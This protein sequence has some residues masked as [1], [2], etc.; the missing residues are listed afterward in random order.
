M[1]TQATFG[2]LFSYPLDGLTFA[3]PLY[4]ANVDDPGPGRPQRRL[5]RDRAR[6]ASTPSTRTAGPARRSGRTRS[7]TRPPAS[8][9]IPPA[10]T[11]ETEDIPNEIGITG[12]PVIDP[13]T[14]TLYLVA[15]TKEVTGGTTNYVNRLHALDLTTGAEKFGGPVVITATV[16]GTGV[17]AVNGEISFNNITA[18]PAAG[19]AARER[20]R[21]T[22]PS[23][24]HGFNPPYHG[25]VMAY[26]ATTLQS[27]LGL[28][29]DA[30]RRR[31]AASGWAATASPPTPP[32]SLYFST[33]NGTFDRSSGGGDYG[34]SL[35]K[36]DAERHGLR[37]LHAAQLA[38]ASTAV[39]STSRS[40]GVVL[41]PDQPGAHPHE[42]D[43]RRQGRDGLRRRPRQHGPRQRRRTT[44]RSS[45]RSSTSSRRAARTTRATT[46]RRSTSTAA[47][48]FVPVKGPVMAFSLTQR[49]A[50]DLPDVEVGRDLQ[51]Q[52]E[53][54][55]A[56]AAARSPISA[57][58]N[59]N[60]IL[61]A[62]Q[63]NGD[64]R[65]GTLH[66]YDP[67]DLAHEY[68]NSDQARVAGRARSV[69]Q[70]HASRSSPTDK[71]Y[72]VSA[73]T[74]DGLRPPALRQDGA[75]ARGAAVSGCWRRV[76]GAYA[77]VVGCRG[78]AR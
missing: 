58:G 3:S 30:E 68:Y 72:V 2:K 63:S 35:V 43:R 55:L 14:N 62:L 51:R 59:T 32:G 41:L 15:A 10:D 29:H 1:S 73:G 25:W 8:R 9:P 67:S 50:L 65:P 70:V 33:G 26:N 5:R 48:Y 12:T 18:E 46:A 42:I 20:R 31:A 60:G 6:H 27:G 49:A 78:V 4:V 66:A 53:H 74:A 22:S 52:D 34:D 37:L 47:V 39:T 64:R 11:G 7:S 17:D 24:N 54:V 76:V 36:L 40:G 56:P 45:S 75:V 28:L 77:S 57:N 61:W 16:P 71:V 19:A 38:D 13:A 69:A 21:S 23:P 44:T